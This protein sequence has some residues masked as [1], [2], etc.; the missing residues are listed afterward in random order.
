M[1]VIYKG[2]PITENFV[3]T[4]WWVTSFSPRV[5]SPNINYLNVNLK[6]KFADHN[7]YIHSG[8]MESFYKYVEE[9]DEGAIYKSEGLSWTETT[10]KTR[11]SGHTGGGHYCGKHPVMCIC[12][13]S[14]VG[15][16]KPCK[17]YS[18]FGDTNEYDI[19]GNS[20]FEFN[21]SF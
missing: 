13:C 21:I 14:T 4:N 12:D 6:V 20:G 7:S 3:Q 10:P 19:I 11:P 8:L 1:D 17:K 2:V 5:Q 18:D 16:G 9:D 15:C